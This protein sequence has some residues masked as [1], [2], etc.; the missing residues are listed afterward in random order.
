MMRP[1][2]Y[3]IFLFLFLQPVIGLVTV[4]TSSGQCDAG[5]FPG[6]YDLTFAECQA[7]EAADPEPNRA[8]AAA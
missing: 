2:I 4:L 5:D 1:F 6:T 8:W 3:L 7:A